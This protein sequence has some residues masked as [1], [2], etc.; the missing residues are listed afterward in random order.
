[1]GLPIGTSA[2]I[3]PGSQEGLCVNFTVISDIYLPPRQLSDPSDPGGI[4]GAYSAKLT[5]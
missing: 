3:A 2:F 4:Q 5:C 1:M